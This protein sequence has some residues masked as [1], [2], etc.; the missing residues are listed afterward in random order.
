MREGNDND[1]TVPKL[2]PYEN[3]ITFMSIYAEVENIWSILSV[4]YEVYLRVN[5]RSVIQMW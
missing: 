3:F 2:C 1:E 5:E 4:S